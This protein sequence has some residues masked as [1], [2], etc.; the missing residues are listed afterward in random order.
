[1]ENKYCREHIGEEYTT[2]E[3]YKVKVID[4]GTKSHYVTIQIEDWITEYQVS[5]IKNGSIKYPF[6]PSVDGVGYFGIGKYVAKINNERTKIYQLWASMIKRCYSSI[7]KKN[8]PCYNEVT[9]CDEWHN[10]Q[11]FAEW[12]EKNYVEGYVLDKDLLIKGNKIYSSETCC[13]IPQEL[14]KFLTNIKKTN[15]SGYVGVCWH[16][17][18]G[19]WEAKINIDK[20]RKTLG[21]FTNPEDAAKAYQEARV[22]EVNKLKELYKDILPKNIIDSIK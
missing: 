1:M 8:N 3:G 16:K 14:N 13:F 10:F 4:G 7:Y 2:N 19:K 9:V 21:R 15:K 12:A 6:Y 17:Q 5:A 18:S 11:T 22:I 20:K